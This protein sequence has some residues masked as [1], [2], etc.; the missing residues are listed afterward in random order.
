MHK[1]LSRAV[2]ELRARMR[3]GQE[4]LAQHISKHGDGG[5]VM[6]APSREVISRWE[7]CSQAPSPMYRAAL[8]RICVKYKHH[9]LVETFRAPVSAWR[10]VGH[11][12]DLTKDD[13]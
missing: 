12:N 3:W 6:V 8:A 5:G 11:V 9:D 2:V 1:G 13:K 10:L 4:D 7:N